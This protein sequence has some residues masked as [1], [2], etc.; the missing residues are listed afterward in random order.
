LLQKIMALGNTP[1]DLSTIED[2]EILFSTVTDINGG[3]LALCKSL[4]S[5]A[6]IDTALTD[7]APSAL[8]PVSS[9]LERLNLSQQGLTRM[10]HVST[11]PVLRELYLQENAITRIEGLQ[12]CPRLQRIWLYGN[13]ITRI[14]GLQPVGEL[15]ELWLQQNKISRISGLEGLAHLANLGLGGNKIS[16]YKDLQRLSSLPSLKSVSF[17][18]IHF[19]SCPVTRLDGYRNFALCYLKQV[20]HLDGLEVT[21]TDRSRAEEAYVEEIL[22]FNAKIEEVTRDGE[23]EANA[24]EARRARTKSH[25]DALRDEMVSAFDMLEKLVKE[26]LGNLH[27]E[28]TRQVRV[29]AENQRAL[30]TSLR[31]ISQQYVARAR[32]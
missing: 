15:R 4:R 25:G 13:K 32:S 12:G 24:I 18:D 8:L 14:D 11:L 23:R 10:V 31:S 30:E 22:A 19:G 6:L 1:A 17:E 5:L 9:T 2:I 26:G 20:T 27:A 28:H 3:G 29:R 7:I 21:G 16:D